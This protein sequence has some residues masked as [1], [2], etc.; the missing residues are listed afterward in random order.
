MKLAHI[1]NLKDQ[2]LTNDKSIAV[3][4][5]C[6]AEYSANLGDYWDREKESAITCCDGLICD[7]VTKRIVYEEVVK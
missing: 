3:C 2:I 4:P 7:L 6:S 1:K 5:S